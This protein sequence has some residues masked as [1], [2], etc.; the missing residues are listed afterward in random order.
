MKSTRIKFL[1]NTLL[2]FPL[3][4]TALHCSALQRYVEGVQGDAVRG[5]GGG[6]G[7]RQGEAQEVPGDGGHADR[8]Q[9]LRPTE[10][11]TV[12]RHRQVR[13]VHFK[14]SFKTDEGTFA[15]SSVI[16]ENRSTTL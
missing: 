4:P 16:L 1:L 15:R 12:L 7:R 6:A 9:E 13:V 3:C 2:F 5:G 11:Q 8:P 10:G 14:L